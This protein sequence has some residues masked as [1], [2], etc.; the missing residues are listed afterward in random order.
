MARTE[1]IAAS[2][3]G[4]L[5]GY[6]DIGVEKV[7]WYTAADDRTCEECSPLHGSEY[8]LIE[9]HGLIPIHPNCRC[10]WIPIV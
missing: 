2:N 8:R 5:Q 10:T 3:E 7:E 1:T 6:G 9:S 4:A